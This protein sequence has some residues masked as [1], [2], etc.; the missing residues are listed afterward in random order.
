[1]NAGVI[2]AAAI[3]AAATAARGFLRSEG[4]AEQALFERLA[5]SA[6]RLGET[7]IGALL[8]ERAVEDVLPVREG[9]QGLTYGPVRVIA[10]VGGLSVPEYAV[11]IAADGCG[12]VRVLRPGAATTVSVG[13]TAGVAATWA[14]LPEPLAQGVVALIAHLFDDRS[15][16]AQPPAGVAA[17]WRPFRR[18]RLM[19]SRRDGTPGS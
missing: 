3:V 13:Y 4:E 9:W 18:M 7:F 2:P 11:D 12:W 10:D 16:T 6:I 17:L 8:F 5:G 1:M 14:D 15:S 19:G